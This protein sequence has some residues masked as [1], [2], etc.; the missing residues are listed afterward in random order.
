ML[1]YLPIMLVGDAGGEMSPALKRAGRRDPAEKAERIEN[2]V[3]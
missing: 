2:R 3:K 1:H